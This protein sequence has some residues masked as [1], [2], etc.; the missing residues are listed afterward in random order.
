LGKIVISAAIGTIAGAIDAAGFFYTAKFFF[1][2]TNVVKRTIA[3]I[4]EILRLIILV[5][6]IIFICSRLHV[7]FLPLAFMALVLSLGGKMVF[8]FKGLKR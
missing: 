4:L 7:M 8:I 1:A 3:G 5:A 6:F 2:N